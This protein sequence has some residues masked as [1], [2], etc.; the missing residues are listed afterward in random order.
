VTFS[1]DGSKLLVGHYG[2]HDSEVWLV[3][4]GTGET[5]DGV[6]FRLRGHRGSI[7]E[8]VFSPDGRSL[9]TTSDADRPKVWHVATGQE[10]C[11]LDALHS[12][13]RQVDFL[14]HGQGLICRGD[15]QPI[16]LLD[17]RGFD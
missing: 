12:A 2:G 11:E 13:C 6:K 3:D 10:L 4:T 9:V 5:I 1:P 14:P 17:W 7:R 16:R 15:R 8:T